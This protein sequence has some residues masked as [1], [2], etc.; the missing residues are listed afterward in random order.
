MG[1]KTT[2]TVKHNFDHLGQNEKESALGKGI[3]MMWDLILA[4][5]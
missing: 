5:H 3:R 1:F 4:F 2:I